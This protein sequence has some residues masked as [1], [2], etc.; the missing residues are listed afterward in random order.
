MVC[1][2][3]LTAVVVATYPMADI[4][5]DGM[6][7]NAFQAGT[8][9]LVHRVEDLPPIYRVSGRTPQRAEAGQ[10]GRRLIP[11]ERVGRRRGRGLQ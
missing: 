10:A 7:A 11:R 5:S 9:A 3:H 8:L 2:V 1:I 4:Y 6:N